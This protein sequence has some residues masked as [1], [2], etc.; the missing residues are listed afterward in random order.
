MDALHNL[1]YLSLAPPTVPTG[2]N[3]WRRVAPVTETT[4]GATGAPQHGTTRP[5]GVSARRPN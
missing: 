1:S 4:H 5:T 3:L 2:P